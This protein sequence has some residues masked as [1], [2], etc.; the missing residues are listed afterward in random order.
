MVDG[1]EA[2]HV[3][4]GVPSPSLKKNVAMGY[5]TQGSSKTGTDVKIEIRKKLYDGVISK[6]PFLPSNYYVNK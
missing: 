1:E 3:T 6:M 4:S 2:G 5:V